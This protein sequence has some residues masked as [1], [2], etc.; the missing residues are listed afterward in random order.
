MNL[1]FRKIQIL[2]IKPEFLTNDMSLPDFDDTDV[3][4]S[5]KDYA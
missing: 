1:L 2:F 5:D 4:L 3:F